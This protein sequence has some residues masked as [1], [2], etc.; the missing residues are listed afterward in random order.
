MKAIKISKEKM[1]AIT[2]VRLGGEIVFTDGERC[3]AL[4]RSAT[5]N[6]EEDILNLRRNC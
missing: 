2:S 1:S 3:E 4:Y 5:L 6:P